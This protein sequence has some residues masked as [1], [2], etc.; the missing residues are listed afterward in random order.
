MSRN[1]QAAIQMRQIEATLD[2]MRSDGITDQ[3]LSL[4][5]EQALELQQIARG[6]ATV[7][8]SEF[9]AAMRSALNGQ[10]GVSETL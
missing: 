7:T 10:G 8:T 2:Q 5:H 3:N 1:Q 6:P 9:Y 4:L